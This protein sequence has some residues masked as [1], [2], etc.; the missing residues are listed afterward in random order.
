MERAP[1]TLE[2]MLR[3]LDR[4]LAIRTT[5]LDTREPALTTYASIARVVEVLAH[6]RTPWPTKEALTRA[7]IR[8]HRRGVSSVFG[9]ALLAAFAPLLVSVRCRL[10]T[11]MEDDE[12]DQ[13]VV[14]TFLVE[15]G[16][17]E[18]SVHPNRALM[19][20]HQN[21]RRAVFRLLGREQKHVTFAAEVASA[22]NVTALDV[23][24]RAT[25]LAP[26]EA[27]ALGALLRSLVGDAL[28]P[29]KLEV[30]ISTHLLGLPIRETPLDGRSLEAVKRERSRTLA[31]LRELL[32]DR[33]V[34][35][36]E[37]LAW[38]RGVVAC[39]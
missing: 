38:L 13:V 19:H 37:E 21:T 35:P 20:L 23:P 9:A 2:S 5:A 4:S 11:T 14:D 10:Q 15:V 7:L 31:R 29:R 34:P 32:A 39:R 25:R 6:E 30:V 3:R 28:A 18:D 1:T 17:F 27:E 8:E 12:V 26:E 36:C 22:T 33:I 24:A 16:R